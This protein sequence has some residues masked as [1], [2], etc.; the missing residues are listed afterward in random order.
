MA[1]IL[2]LQN[3]I[4]VHLIRVDPLLACDSC[5]NS[6]I[7]HTTKGTQEQDIHIIRITQDDTGNR[8]SFQEGQ[9]TCIFNIALVSNSLIV[10]LKLAQLRCALPNAL[11]SCPRELQPVLP[12]HTMP[13]LQQTHPHAENWR[14]IVPRR[15]RS[16]AMSLSLIHI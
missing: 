10:A 16:C 9:G 3:H 7:E 6:R 1:I 15:L 8:V 5:S 2:Q 14:T 13:L 4:P 11:I 12:P